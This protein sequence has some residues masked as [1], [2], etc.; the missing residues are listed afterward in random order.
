MRETV[1]SLS[2]Y[3][4]LSG[5][6]SPWFGL[7][8]LIFDL[9]IGISPAVILGIVTGI[10]NVSFSLGFIYVGLFLRRLLQN[11]SSSIVILLYL[12]GGLAILSSFLSLL[13]GGGMAAII[14]LL[15]T[16][17]ILW[18]LLKNVRRL[19]SET[20]PSTATAGEN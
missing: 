2:I 15:I 12:S 9:R 13:G 7:Q 6:A 10:A 20:Q 11:S 1:R 16:L 4:I 14:I 17:L 18:Y 3:F 5:L 8:N 19:A